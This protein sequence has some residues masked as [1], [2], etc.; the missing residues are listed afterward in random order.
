MR[1]AYPPPQFRV[2]TYEKRSGTVQYSWEWD[3]H[4]Y[5]EPSMEE[6]L[7]ISVTS[8]AHC[9]HGRSWVHIQTLESLSLP[10]HQRRARLFDSLGCTLDL[11]HQ[12]SAHTRSRHKRMHPEIQSPQSIQPKRQRQTGPYFSVMLHMIYHTTHNK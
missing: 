7:I 9:S 5:P 1:S 6:D 12:P 10:F 4:L 3:R 8:L 2:Q 11:F